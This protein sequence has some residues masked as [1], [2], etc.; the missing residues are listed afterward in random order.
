MWR[1]NYSAKYGVA[2]IRIHELREPIWNTYK[3]VDEKCR[4]DTI[5]GLNIDY[6]FI[7]MN[8]NFEHYDIYISPFPGMP[9]IESQLLI[10][11]I[12]ETL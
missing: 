11:D 8:I 2:Q 12:L 9:S 5:R 6:A 1:T 4:V 7:Y 3:E 10:D